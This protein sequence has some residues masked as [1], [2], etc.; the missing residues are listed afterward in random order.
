M[1]R[2]YPLRP[3]SSDDPQLRGLADALELDIFA[4]EPDTVAGSEIQD[5]PEVVTNKTPPGFADIGN[6]LP[7]QELTP[8]NQ[9]GG[10]LPT[11]AFSQPY[12]EHTGVDIDCSRRGQN[13]H[14]FRC[15]RGLFPCS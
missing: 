8:P 12:G 2:S 7:S 14:R 10:I 1:N 3:E 9:R 5:E 13:G 4:L 15:Y 6:L 11:F